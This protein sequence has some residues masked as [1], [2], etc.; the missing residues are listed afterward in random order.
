M[1]SGVGG[2]EGLN[3]G[4]GGGGMFNGGNMEIH[5]EDSDGEA[6]LFVKEALAQHYCR[7]QVANS[8]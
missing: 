1:D 3:I 7:Y 5:E 4:G 6:W 2:R 8:W